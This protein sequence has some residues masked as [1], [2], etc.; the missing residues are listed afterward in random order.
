MSISHVLLGVLAAGPAHG[1][2]L[3]REHDARFPGAKELAYGQV[4]AALQRLERDGLAEVAE[5]VQ[6]SGPERTVYALTPAGQAELERWLSEAES[7]G[8]YAADDLVR[9]AVTA[10]RLGADA[11]GYLERQREVHLARMR[12]LLA[13]Q[14]ATT[15]P[16]GRSA[17]D[18]AVFHLDADLR[19]LEAAA[20]RIAQTTT[21]RKGDPS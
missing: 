12:E 18:H 3:K 20:A 4:Y 16:A 1:Y 21:T 13:I 11:R 2:D 8:P 7:A 14:D 19:W 17:I 15:D 6:E 9:K 10:L 5:T